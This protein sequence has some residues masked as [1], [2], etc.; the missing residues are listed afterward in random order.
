M[1]AKNAD[2]ATKYYQSQQTEA[3]NFFQVKQIIMPTISQHK[4]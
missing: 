4:M 2:I 3:N 1:F